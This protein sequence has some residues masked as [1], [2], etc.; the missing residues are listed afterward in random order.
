MKRFF[1][2]VFTELETRFPMGFKNACLVFPTQR[3]GL[4]FKKELAEKQHHPAWAPEVFSSEQFFSEAGGRNRADSVTLSLELFKV[5]RKFFPEES[6]ENFYFW[7]SVLIRDFD[8]TDRALANPKALFTNI[9][10]LKE[11]GQSFGLEEVSEELIKTFWTVI[12]KDTS[13][14]KDAFLRTWEVLFEIYE[15]FVAVLN[16]K[17]MA[18]PGMAYREMA[19]NPEPYIMK[20]K[21]WKHIVFAG[22]YGLSPAEEKFLQALAK[23][24]MASFIWDADEMYLKNP[25][26]EAGNYFRSGILPADFPPVPHKFFETVP[27]KINIISTA[28]AVQQA[29]AA[30]D[31]LHKFKDFKAEETAMVLP[32]EGLLFPVLH[33]IGPGIPKLN[34]TMGYP[35]RSGPMASLIKVLASMQ[36]A[37]RKGALPVS[38]IRKLIS[39]P[40]LAGFREGKFTA[41]Y[42]NEEVLKPGYVFVSCKKLQSLALPAGLKALFIHPEN[43]ADFFSCMLGLF[44]YLKLQFERP[45]MANNLDGEFLAAYH[46]ALIRLEEM[47]YETGL[48][49]DVEQV[50]KMYDDLS[51]DLRIPFTGEPL[52]GL[53]IMGLLETRALSFKN[54]FVFSLNEQSFPGR[55]REISFIP[56]ALRKAFGLETFKDI[57]ARASYNFFRLLQRAE[58]VWLFCNSGDEGVGGNEKSR[59][60]LQLEYEL[61]K[62]FPDQ[63]I[64]ENHTLVI[65]PFLESVQPI[66]VQKSKEILATL[67]NMKFSPSSLLDYIACPLKFYFRKVAGLEEIDEPGESMDAKQIGSVFHKTMEM[68]YP[69]KGKVTGDMLDGFKPLIAEKVRLAFESE[70]TGKGGPVEGRNLILMDILGK[71]VEKMI[72][73]DKKQTPFEIIFT[74]RF[75]PIEFPVSATG[76]NVKIVGVVDR[77]DEYKGTVRVLDYKTGEFKFKKRALPSME[78]LF[79]EPDAFKKGVFQTSLYRLMIESLVPK[80]LA[81]RTG[82]IPLKT[83]GEQIELMDEEYSTESAISEFKSLL[84]KLFTEILNPNTPFIQTENEK[85][86]E[87]CA[88]KDIC[89]R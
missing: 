47:L 29:K 1:D 28:H 3:A 34:V 71:L 85:I 86:C 41:N 60:L 18:Y 79:S 35:A 88:F 55:T 14:V 2:Q 77:V 9:K 46:V 33:A 38:E 37:Y 76:K 20:C 4:F 51:S 52:V 89:V 82:I 11:I 49:P 74:E 10:N 63:L 62:I 53:Q 6:F 59:F 57:E 83:P 36:G 87:Y 69:S 56:F 73:L 30:G 44:R 84:D 67:G 25:N 68:L 7:G 8:A 50:W 42:W 21:K 58:N 70:I 23:E 61:K 15:E 27:K 13:R 80:G 24:G 22:L 54:L 65:P 16:A 75:I 81:I 45:G 12:H 5:Y 31:L 39:H 48:N 66:V 78:E 64:I 19:E 43:A 72:D 32:D 40:Y 26:M 17:N